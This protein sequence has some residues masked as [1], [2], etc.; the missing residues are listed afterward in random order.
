MPTLP[1]TRTLRTVCVSVVFGVLLLTTA[2]PAFATS[3]TAGSIVVNSN[4]GNPEATFNLVGDDGG[5]LSGLIR[6][7]AFVITLFPC[8]D[9]CSHAI[10]LGAAGSSFVG[11]DPFGAHGNVFAITGPPMV[12]NSGAGTYTAPFSFTGMYCQTAGGAGAPPHPCVTDYPSLTGG[13]IVTLPV[14]TFTFSGGPAVNYQMA[15]PATYT[16]MPIPEPA[17]L[18][19]VGSGLMM[20]ARRISR[21]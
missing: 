10:D 20:V 15:G 1:A 5:S 3:I 17:S 21:R 11:S 4:F 9:P 13:G 12:L 14:S 7:A 19:L 18:L 8:A 16:F 2:A 6:E